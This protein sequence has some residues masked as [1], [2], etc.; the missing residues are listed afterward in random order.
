[1]FVKVKR[2]NGLVFLA[3]DEKVAETLACL[4]G[5][6]LGD[7]EHS[8]RAHTDAIYMPLRNVGLDCDGSAWK[9][10]KAPITA[11]EIGYDSDS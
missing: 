4:T 6:V 8:Y 7:C 3:M 1:M 9:R 10:F 11:K 5:H 2:E